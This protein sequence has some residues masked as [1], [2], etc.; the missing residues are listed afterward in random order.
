MKSILFV[1]LGNICRSPLAEGIARHYIQTHQLDI[2]VDSAG[3]GNWHV[4]EAP[5]DNSVKVAA[6]HGIDISHQRA[7]QFKTQDILDF[8]LIIALDQSN[9]NDLKKLG[10]S[11]LHKLGAFGF[12]HEDVP[13]PYFF[14]G[15]EGFEK[16]YS[17]IE[18]CVHN[19]LES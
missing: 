18:T 15:F 11:N 13:D 17:M 7:R 12:N 19:L 14:P 6:H 16:V 5:C 4:G 1:C 8:D 9:Y 3:T 10:A 2:H